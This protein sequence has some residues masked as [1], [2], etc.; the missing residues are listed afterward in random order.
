MSSLYQSQT[1]HQSKSIFNAE[2]Y[3][4]KHVEFRLIIFVVLMHETK[5]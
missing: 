1:T 4:N 3:F 5:I 2:A